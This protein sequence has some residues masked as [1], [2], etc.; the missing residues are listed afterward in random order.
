MK[1]L[2]P[3]YNLQD[4]YLILKVLVGTFIV[5]GMLVLRLLEFKIQAYKRNDKTLLIVFTGL[6]IFW[7][8]TRGHKIGTDTSNYHDFYFLQSL[9][10]PDYSEFFV[11]FNSDLIFEVLMFFTFIF[12]D[13]TVFT[14]VVACVFNIVLFTFVRKFTDYGNKGSSL[15]LFLTFASFFSFTSLELNIIRNAVAISFFLIGLHYL[16]NDYKKKTLVFFI[17]ALLSHLTSLIPIVAILIALYFQNTPI[18]YFLA[19]YFAMILAS[20]FG[21]GLHTI[22]FLQNLDGEYA[23]RLVFQGETTYRI[24]FR[25]DFVLYNSFFLFGLMIISKMKSRTEKMIFRYYILTSIIFFLNFY[26]PFSDR[27]GVYSW[28]CLPILIYTVLINNFPRSY[29]HLSSLALIF[30]FV[31]N[32]LILFP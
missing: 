2:F 32:Y 11:Y 30:I 19:L 6:I 20:F 14:F 15:F 9:Y 12:K 8:G 7:A 5:L 28:I 13:F 23:N 17:L 1:Y 27:I 16:L 26:I 31:M 18:K 22:S 4:Y 24:G 25:P 10:L 29:L 21:F 3:E